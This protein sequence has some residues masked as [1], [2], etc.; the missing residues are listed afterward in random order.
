MCDGGK[1]ILQVRALDFFLPN[2][3]Y[4]LIYFVY[5]QEL[6]WGYRPHYHQHGFAPGPDACKESGHVIQIWNPSLSALMTLLP[7]RTKPTRYDSFWF[8]FDPQI[9][10][11][12]KSFAYEEFSSIQLQTGK[13]FASQGVQY[14]KGS[15]EV[16]STTS[17]TIVAFDLG[18]QT[19]SELS[20]PYSI[21]DIKWYGQ[22]VLRVLIGKLFVISTNNI[23]GGD[24]EVWV[25]DEYGVAGSWVKCH[26]LSRFSNYVHDPCGFNLGLRINLSKSKLYGV[27]VSE[28]E[29]E[30]MAHMLKCRYGKLPFMYIGLPI[31][32]NMN[33]VGSRGIIVKKFKDTLSEWKAKSISFGGRLTLV[34]SVL[35]VAISGRW[36]S[37]VDS[38]D[39]K[40]VSEIDRTEVVFSSS[41]GR[42]LGNGDGIWFW[43]DKWAGDFKLCERFPRLFRFEGDKN[44]SV[45]NHDEWGSD[46]W[47]SILDHIGI[48]LDST[49]CPC[50]ENAVETIDHIMVR[51]PLVSAVWS[52]IFLWWGI[53]CFNGS[54]LSDILPSHGL[55]SSKLESV[56]QAVIQSSLYLIWKARNSKVFKSREMVV[57]DI[58]FEIQLIS[59]F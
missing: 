42:K 31:G 27:G 40:L 1:P 46:G 58:F 4:F 16:Y 54:L 22:N 34:Q 21:M 23:M 56:W 36:R 45:R 44:V 52:K 12:K 10:D 28:V 47:R 57:A 2:S 18:L 14:E 17:Q 25:R 50:Y 30:E 3:T 48:D 8:D 24:W 6:G 39:K 7:Y 41:F 5:P 13:L 33:K 51:F 59:F 55:V 26:L 38:S 15:W 35:V 53:G 19:F 9:D 32:V 37:V 11:Y 49:L 43:K 29:V 20:L